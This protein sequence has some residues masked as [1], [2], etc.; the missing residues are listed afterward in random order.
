[1]KHLLSIEEYRDFWDYP[2]IFLSRFEGRLFLFDCEFDEEAEDFRDEFK[3]YLMPELSAEELDTAWVD[4]SKKAIRYCGNVPTATIT[5]D[6]TRR[7][8]ADATAAI[9]LLEAALQAELTS[10]DCLLASR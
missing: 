7:L 6:D 3:I 4:L 1:M 5:F 9:P 2:R 8:Q 10:G